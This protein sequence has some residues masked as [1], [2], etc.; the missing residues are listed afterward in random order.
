VHLTA[1]KTSKIADLLVEAGMGGGFAQKSF[2]ETVAV[3]ALL[4]A[5]LHEAANRDGIAQMLGQ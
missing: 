4:L 5:R 2:Q 3:K 1:S